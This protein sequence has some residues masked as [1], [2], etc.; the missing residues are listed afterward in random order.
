[1]GTYDPNQRKERLRGSPFDEQREEK[2]VIGTIV[3][4][5]PETCS[6]KVQ[7]D[8]GGG[9]YESLPLPGLI[10]DSQGGG[11]EVF[12]PRIGQRVELKIGGRAGVRIRGYVPTASPGLMSESA[13][14]SLF[15]ENLP[16]NQRGRVNFRGRLPKNL[17][18]GDWCRI[19][20][21]NQYVGCFDGGV[22]SLF[23]APWAQVN[24]TGGTNTDTV[25]IAGR[26]LNILTGF[27]QLNCKSDNG[28]QSIEFMG[29]MDQMT[30]TGYDQTKWTYQGGLG[31][32]DSYSLFSIT[33]KS[34]DP[35]YRVNLGT[36]SN[37]QA[38]YAGEHIQTIQADK[39]TA[40]NGGCWNAIV[41]SAYTEIGGDLT[42]VFKKNRTCRIN[43]NETV[44][45][46]G[47]SVLTIQGSR[48]VTCKT[49]AHNVSGDPTA[50]PGAT[51]YALNIGNGSWDVKI[52]EPI[53]PF[54]KPIGSFNVTV[55]GPTD[56]IN[57]KSKS[58]TIDISAGRT[59]TVK[60]L[61]DLTL[62]GAVRTIVNGGV[63]TLGGT[64]VNEP[65]LKGQSVLAAMQTFLTA[66]SSAAA[67]APPTEPAIKGLVGPAN[68]LASQLASCLS[69]KVFVT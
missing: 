51:S 8:E 6:C 39:G 47:K 67:A 40:V 55:F 25:N 48:T 50:L 19:G 20:N 1:M 7:L 49:L 69:T 38:F 33:S 28:R 57:L 22:A 68:A 27:G 42:E 9:V 2:S 3:G 43:I 21:Q 37:Y 66:F 53:P 5:H 13:N 32:G 64:A 23:G 45:I 41:G 17:V 36:N 60:A 46:M 29:G 54:Q 44:S 61:T 30:E 11:G 52:G 58:G 18:P 31:I 26:R 12:V 34:G 56:G 15:P 35:I 62:T 4:V 10:Q 63:V 16:S 59:T 24:V 14:P 65:V